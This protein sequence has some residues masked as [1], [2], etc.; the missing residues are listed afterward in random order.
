MT[1]HIVLPS[2][3]LPYNLQ[4]E[5][6][7]QTNSEAC[8]CTCQGGHGTDSA[9]WQNVVGSVTKHSQAQVKGQATYW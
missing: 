3:F 6:A 8:T 2:I 5:S 4:V 9:P 1:I 7:S